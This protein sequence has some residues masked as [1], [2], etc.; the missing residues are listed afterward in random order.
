MRPHNEENLPRLPI[1][2]GIAGFTL[3]TFLLTQLVQA[4]PA[5]ALREIQPRQNSGLEEEIRDGIY[6]RHITSTKP[7]AGLEEMILEVPG[8][9]RYRTY[10]V[11]DPL[12]SVFSGELKGRTLG[13]R[14]G[15]KGVPNSQLESSADG[16]WALVILKLATEENLSGATE[17]LRLIEEGEVIFLEASSVLDP[18]N[19][20]ENP[21][22]KFWDR[23]AEEAVMSSLWE[24][25]FHMG[26]DR[27]EPSIQREVLATISRS[28]D[29]WLKRIR[30]GIGEAYET[31]D[32]DLIAH[33][34][35]AIMLLPSRDEEYVQSLIQTIF[36]TH[37]QDVMKQV[38]QESRPSMEI[39][40]QMRTLAEHLR[41]SLGG[42]SYR[43]QIEEILGSVGTGLPEL[44]NPLFMTGHFKSIAIP[45]GSSDPFEVPFVSHWPLDERRERYV[46]DPL[47][48][49]YQAENTGA[50]AVNLVQTAVL[51]R[52]VPGF[53][54]EDV[55]VSKLSKGKDPEPYT[56]VVKAA[57]EILPK[58]ELWRQH[59]VAIVTLTSQMTLAQL[60]QEALSQWTGRP[61][62][63]IL[64]IEHS[65]SRLGI[66]A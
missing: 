63:E 41:P 56:I 12:F 3:L 23:T 61:V 4:L 16:L 49:F 47:R 31:D 11:A 28:N 6:L 18:P 59:H 43:T 29:A 25:R 30:E 35:I 46:V 13:T 34:T 60:I 45:F 21:E 26:I 38:R 19:V 52:Q 9:S 7:T 53:Q 5:L 27:L 48:V 50:A 14:I 62:G 55:Q 54:S 37:L 51:S 42:K 2:Q 36:P 15:P 39:V 1:R 58:E 8:D 24:E 40:A 66:Y 33:E 17:L 57:D 10:V 64:Q 65:K 44:P 22:S 20:S 32:A